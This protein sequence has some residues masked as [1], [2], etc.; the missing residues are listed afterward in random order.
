MVPLLEAGDADLFAGFDRAHRKH[1]DVGLLLQRE[2]ERVDASEDFLI[3]VE[4]VHHEPHLHAIPGALNQLDDELLGEMARTDD[5]ELD[6]DGG[7]S[8]PARQSDW[9][10]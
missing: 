6:V 8:R 7:A 4:R 10:S 2:D 1:L 3:G 9:R 5:V